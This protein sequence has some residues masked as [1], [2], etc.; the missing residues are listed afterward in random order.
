MD[1]RQH[2]VDTMGAVPHAIDTMFEM[3]PE[4]AE[5]YTDI[6]ELIYRERPDGLPLATKELLLTAFDVA[7]VNVGGAKAHLGSARRAGLTRTQLKET[8]LIAFLV[9][10]VASF[11]LVGEHLWKA[12]D[13][14]GGEPGS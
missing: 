5:H 6:R 2:F 4:F 11:G 1:R 9:Q 8:L 7:V 12:W 10:G 3:D 14:V 13:Q